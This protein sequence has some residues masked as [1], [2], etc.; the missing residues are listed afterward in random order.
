MLPHSRSNWFAWAG[1]ALLLSGVLLLTNRAQSPVYAQTEQT[2][3]PPSA[4]LPNRAVTVSGSGMV[5]A[6]PDIAIVTVGVQTDAK[7]ASQALTQN[8]TQMQAV[9]DTLRKANIAAADIRTTSVQLYPRYDNQ[10]N[11]QPNQQGGTEPNQPVGYTA[12]NS[13]EV[14]VRNLDNLG[15]LLDQVVSAGGNQ[16]TGIRF[17]LSDP[18]KAMDQAR[19]AA[20]KDAMHKAQQLATLAGARLG[21]VV[22][23]NESSS[24]PIPYAAMQARADTASSVPVSPGS[25]PVTVD[26]QV[27]WEL[28]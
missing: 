18:S 12:T 23:I 24:A 22:T 5:N 1:I 14:T 19:E 25:Q 7:T 4:A 20:M 13:V 28:Q 16:I 26:L 11:P 15:S 9:M 21:A 8:S 10:P 2:P 3:T 27:T 17:D 6:T